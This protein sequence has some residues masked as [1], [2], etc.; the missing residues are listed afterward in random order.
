MS[1]SG[2]IGWEVR[3]RCVLTTSLTRDGFG[4]RL[5]ATRKR[6]GM[7]QAELGGDRYTGSYISHLESGRRAASHDVVEFL[8]MRL[9]VTADELG[10]EPS[11]PE[12]IDNLDNTQALEHLLVAERAWY[13]RDW[14]TAG[15]L[16]TRA[17]ASALSAGQ[18]ERHWQAL[19]VRAQAALAEGDFADAIHFA[20]RLADHQVAA[21]SPTLRAQALSL[22]A[23]AHRVGDELPMALVHAG[24]AVEL[25]RE[26]PP[27]VL[28]DALMCLISAALEAGRPT[29]ATDALCTRLED[30]LPHVESAHVRGVVYWALGT[31]AF[32]SGNVPKGLELHDLAM[33]L[34][35][36][37][38]DLRMWLRLNRS[39][40]NCRLDAG[41]TDGV[42]EM[43]EVAR[44]GLSLIGTAFDM[45]E[46]RLAEAK[47]TLLEGHPQKAAGMVEDL[48]A[49]PAV[50]PAVISN[51][52][53]EELLAEIE[54]DLGR[55]DR[56]RA[57]FIRA[58]GLYGKQEQFR[59]ASQCWQRAAELENVTVQN[60]SGLAAAT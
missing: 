38:R 30:V 12:P 48:L 8:A 25:A 2:Q 60:A 49:D 18:P 26:A 23:T 21:T 3:R 47:L 54:L 55:P 41:L 59:R 24:Q 56:A 37:R 11:L 20:E 46:L 44:G 1:T 29:A 32:K 15:K 31:A 36:P 34:L 28:A 16:A 9:G 22:S 52:K 45:F 40:A 14:A 10:M 42:R 35:S 19:Y 58:A 13:D 50:R 51:G 7:S 5:R 4:A 57:A 33:E 27:I 53:G 39:A 43:L 6:L 17:A